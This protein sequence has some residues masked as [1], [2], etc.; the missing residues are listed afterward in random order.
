MSLGNVQG[1]HGHGEYDGRQEM[2]VV[3]TCQKCKQ[4][5][6]HAHCSNVKAHVKAKPL[7]F[8]VA[9]WGRDRPL[10]QLYAYCCLIPLMLQL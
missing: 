9:P 5:G 4:P 10:M 3:Y 7:A 6:I 8:R 2:H 1:F